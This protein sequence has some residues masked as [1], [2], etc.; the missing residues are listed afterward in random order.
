MRYELTPYNRDV[1]DDELLADLRRVGQIL[2]GRKVSMRAYDKQGKY[3]ASTLQMRFRSWLIALEKAGLQ[4]TFNRNISNDALFENLASI[5]AAVG[6]QP[7]YRDITRPLSQFS[8]ST[9]HERFGSW[10]EALRAFVHWASEG[11]NGSL[12]SGTSKEIEKTEGFGSDETL[13][14]RE[15]NVA[16]APRNPNLRQRFT[17]FMR[18][19]FRCQACGRSPITHPGTILHADHV[20]PWS[21]GGMT[22]IE[23]LRTLCDQCNLGK[24]VM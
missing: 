24:G 19:G 7:K 23:N 4:K 3:S 14:T 13:S 8:A 15:P 5:W 21:R 6:R 18:D 2:D 12:G 16:I 1:T 11:S 17:V 9:Y 20:K 22:S 10:R